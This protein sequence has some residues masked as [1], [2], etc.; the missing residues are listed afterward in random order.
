MAGRRVLVIDCEPQANAT[1]GLGL[2][3]GLPER[4][5]YDLFMSRIPDFPNIE[6]ADIIKKTSS[7]IVLAPAHPDLVGAEP[8]LYNVGGRAAILSDA[9]GKVSNQYDFILI[10]TPPS[11]GQFVINGL[12]AA[13]FVIVTLDSGTFALGGIAPLRTIF[14]DFRQD[15]NKEIRADMAIVTRFGESPIRVM[16][17]DEISP[18]KTIFSRILELFSG[19]EPP[20][21]DGNKGEEELRVEQERL[22]SIL[23]EVQRLFKKVYTIPYSPEIYESQKRGLPISH[24]F[25][26]CSAGQAYRI[27]AD[28]VMKWT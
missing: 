11:M 17:K 16:T 7:G 3:P 25:P 2:D 28:E 19:K 23:G 20:L 14:E 15:L 22:S 8:Y 5:M 9:I 27:I 6:L 24:I 10:D 26:E 13:D 4:N 1:A 18:K 12:Y 21:P